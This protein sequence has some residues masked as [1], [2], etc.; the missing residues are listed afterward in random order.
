M[1]GLQKPRKATVEKQTLF[2]ITEKW[3]GVTLSLNT[4]NNDNRSKETQ[5]S[6]IRHFLDGDQVIVCFE[7]SEVD[8]KGIYLRMLL[9]CVTCRHPCDGQWT[10]VRVS[11][12]STLTLGI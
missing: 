2:A 4:I 6:F 3:A 10:M 11:F 7:C 8:L 1:S 5:Y 9:F 12:L